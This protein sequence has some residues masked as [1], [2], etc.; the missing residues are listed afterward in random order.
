MLLKPARTALTGRTRLV[1]VPDAVV[2]S[3]DEFH[4]LLVDEH[5]NVLTQ[6][7]SAVTALRPQGLESVAVLLGGEACS[8]EVVSG[9]V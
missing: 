5:V 8:A 3:P 2:R 7:P 4:D 1:I 9:R 6:T